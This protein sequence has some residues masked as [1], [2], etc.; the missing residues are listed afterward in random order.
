MVVVV[1]M[2]VVVGGVVVREPFGVFKAT[3][4]SEPRPVTLCSRYGRFLVPRG[5]GGVVMTVVVVV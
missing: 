2:G 3:G 1:C 5:G 4:L